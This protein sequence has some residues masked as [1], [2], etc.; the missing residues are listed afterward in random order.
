MMS[1]PKCEATRKVEILSQE[2]QILMKGKEIRFQSHSYRCNHCGEEF[3]T[4]E[5]LDHNLERAREAYDQLYRTPTK[6][7]LVKLRKKYNASQKAFGLLLGFGELTMN[8]YEQ[9]ATPDATHRLLLKIAE[10]PYVF[11][12]IYNENKSRIG[13]RQRKKVES[14][15]SF[16]AGE[17]TWEKLQFP[18]SQSDS[19]TI[20]VIKS[21]DAKEVHYG[22]QASNESG[23][24]MAVFDSCTPVPSYLVAEAKWNLTENAHILNLDNK[25]DLH[26]I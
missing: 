14:S 12:A 21:V 8:K 25:K 6:D 1:C 19:V 13:L 10:N 16:V 11:Q 23:M 20:C 3:D 26:A 7:D 22:T 18:C 17:S 2:K 4:A 24:R 5:T 9:G 15:N